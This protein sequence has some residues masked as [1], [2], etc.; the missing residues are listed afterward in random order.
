[1]GKL[2]EQAKKDFWSYTDFKHSVFSEDIFTELTHP[3]LRIQKFAETC[4]LNLKK[5]RG[6]P[7][8]PPKI[9][10]VINA[11]NEAPSILG[12]LY[13]FG[14]NENAPTTEV[15]VV[16]NASTDQTA[17]I[18]TLSGTRV[19]RH[20][21]KGCAGAVRAGIFAAKGEIILHTDADGYSSPHLL[22]SVADHFD[23]HSKIDA[24]FGPE[25]YVGET[26]PSVKV[27]AYNIAKEIGH[28]LLSKLS[29]KH[30]K[31]NGR[32]FAARREALMAFDGAFDSDIQIA[33]D[34]HAAL[35]FINNGTMGIIRDQDAFI[36]TSARRLEEVGF[37]VVAWQRLFSI[38][39]PFILGNNFKKGS[40]DKVFP[41]IRE[42]I[43]TD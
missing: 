7:S 18:S 21:I 12:L 13:S 16:D 25:K 33:E 29:Y 40:F 22:R 37:F 23:N 11:Y 28:T 43:S 32:N 35:H 15:I 3:E 1:M 4:A 27:E 6:E 30:K 38:D 19:I 41:A 39:L 5:L 9:S 8:V 42:N 14:M 31:G 10:V 26:G 17:Y 36:I 24:F 34:L 2:K 20:E